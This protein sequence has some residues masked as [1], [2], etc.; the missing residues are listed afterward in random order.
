ML[1]NGTPLAL[2][3]SEG[4]ALL[5][6]A[7]NFQLPEKM[8]DTP[9]NVADRALAGD[10][11]RTLYKAL[12]EESPVLTGPERLILFGPSDNF[13]VSGEGRAKQHRMIDTNKEVTITINEDALSGLVWILVCCLHPGSPVCQ[14]IGAQEDMFWP[15]AEKIKRTKIIRETIGLNKATPRRWKTDEEFVEKKGEK[16]KK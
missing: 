8:G 16:E 9:Y 13:E 3:C 15:L 12:K 5:R 11:V 2:T 14:T 7:A 4:Q 6:I 1:K 10:E